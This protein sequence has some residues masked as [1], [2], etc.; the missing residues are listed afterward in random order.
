VERVYIG[1]DKIGMVIGSGG[2]TVREIQEKTGTEIEFDDDTG[3]AIVM[4][5]DPESIK[6]AAAWVRQI[7]EGLKLGQMFR[8]KVTEL[9]E[10]G[11]FVETIPTGADGLVHVSHIADGFVQ[12]PDD[13]LQVGME[14]DVKVIHVDEVTGKVK[15]SIKEALRDLGKPGLTP[16]RPVTPGGPPPERRFPERPRDGGFGRGRPPRRGGPGPGAFRRGEGRY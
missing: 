13:Y 4:S 14:V 10:F 9:R 11:A 16:I 1:T 15:M 2:K 3:H 12:R 6:K 7:A 8:A 5:P